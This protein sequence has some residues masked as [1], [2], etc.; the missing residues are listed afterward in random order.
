MKNISV[1]VYLI[2]DD[3]SIALPEEA[4][5]GMRVVSVGPGQTLSEAR[6]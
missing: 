5:P 1:V 3:V 2:N 4:I 6:L